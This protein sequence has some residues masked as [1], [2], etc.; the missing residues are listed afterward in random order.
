VPL[1]SPIY[2]TRAGVVTRIGS[3]YLGDQAVSIQLDQPEAGAQF[4]IFGHC[5][6]ALVSVGQHVQPPMVIALAGTKGASSGVHLHL[7]ADS[8]YDYEAP[9][10]TDV[11]PVPFLDCPVACP[12]PPA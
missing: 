11:D 10:G 4:L 8:T 7:R 6:Q 5:D 9:P 2:A 1:D 12:S 3:D